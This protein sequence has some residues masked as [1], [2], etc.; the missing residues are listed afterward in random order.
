MYSLLDQR[1]IS[2]S[3]PKA[4]ANPRPPKAHP[5][6]NLDFSRVDFYPKCDTQRELPRGL[7]PKRPE[8]DEMTA[9]Y[10]KKEM[11]R[12]MSG[13]GTHKDL[14]NINFATTD[15]LLHNFLAS[16]AVK[17]FVKKGMLEK[18]SDFED[19]VQDAVDK[20][21]GRPS[22][23]PGDRPHAGFGHRRQAVAN[24][25]NG[26]GTVTEVLEPLSSVRAGELVSRG[27][28]SAMRPAGREAKEQKE[29]TPKVFAQSGTVGAPDV[30]YGSRVPGKSRIVQESIHQ[31]YKDTYNR[32]NEK[33]HELNNASK[34][35]RVATRGLAE[36]IEK[37]VRHYNVKLPVKD[38]HTLT[39]G[40]FGQ[41][42][43]VGERAFGVK[44]IPKAAPPPAT[45]NPSAVFSPHKS[46]LRS[47]QKPPR[48]SIYGSP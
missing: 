44:P 24:A 42:R 28:Y 13:Y 31:Q 12:R 7:L 17:S 2:Y 34:P 33:Y 19:L 38:Q 37:M 30:S 11:E 14:V 16:H 36:E 18:G 20:L 41:V 48:M 35:A 26:A 46:L 22:P 5:V 4:A 47:P 15:E 43:E 23:L 6:K 40:N 29:A 9:Y 32:F 45:V 21:T 8:M 1:P 27:A 3:L 10:R 25:V 39:T